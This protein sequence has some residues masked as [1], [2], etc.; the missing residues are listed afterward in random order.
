MKFGYTIIYVADV[1]GTINFYQKAFQL[2]KLFMHEGLQYGELDTGFTKLAFASEEMAKNNGIKIIKNRSQNQIAG[3]E[4]ALVAKDINKAYKHAINA[5]AISV[6]EPNEK[7]WGQ[8]IAYVR[9]LNGILIEICS[10]IGE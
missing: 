9:D 7:P 2:K 5:G 6:Q 1:V 4:I 8:T 3:F 10:P